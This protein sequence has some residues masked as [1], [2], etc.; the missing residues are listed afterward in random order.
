[1]AFL[2]G[3]GMGPRAFEASA[4][5][6]E[7]RTMIEILKEEGIIALSEEGH[8]ECPGKDLHTTGNQLED[9]KIYFNPQG[10]FWAPY[11]HCF[12]SSCR[13][14]LQGCIHRMFYQA[15]RRAA[16]RGS[17]SVPFR[18]GKKHKTTSPSISPDEV[19]ANYAWTLKEIEVD[20]DHNVDVPAHLHHRLLFRLFDPDDVLWVAD[21][22]W[23]SGHPRFSGNFRCVSDLIA[24][25]ASPGLYTCPNTFKEGSFSRSAEML[26]TPKYLVVESDSLTHDE[27]GAVFNWM[28]QQGHV[29]RAVIDTGNKSLHG[30]FDRPFE[31]AIPSLKRDLIHL[32]C[33]PKMFGLSQPC[34]LPGAIRPETKKFQ[35]LI[36]FNHPNYTP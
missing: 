6:E 33:D 20:P 15:A 18:T 3:Q 12:H 22:L 30:W 21:E 25:G 10:H 1:M 24:D 2:T 17:G 8:V 32:G 36:Y 27:S 35:R 34:R 4:T 11:L 14:K 28:K 26:Q 7:V 23:Q 31:E 19:K 13:Q 5:E 29:L 9:C 16:L